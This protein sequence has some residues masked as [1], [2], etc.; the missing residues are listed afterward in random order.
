MIPIKIASLLGY[1]FGPLIRR[2]IY[3]K[4]NLESDKSSINSVINGQVSKFKNLIVNHYVKTPFGRKVLSELTN[5]DLSKKTLDNLINEEEDIKSFP[6]INRDDLINHAL[7]MLVDGSRPDKLH[8]F[9]TSGTTT[10]IQVVRYA[11]MLDVMQG[12]LS[13]LEAFKLGGI[14]PNDSI[15]ML[16]PSDSSLW[17]G[18]GLIQLVVPNLRYV[19][20]SLNLTKSQVTDLLRSKAILSYTTVPIQVFRDYDG[21]V[22]DLRLRNDINLKLIILTGGYASQ[23]NISGLRELLGKSESELKI[24]NPLMSIECTGLT[25][26]CSKGH[27]HLVTDFYHAWTRPDGELVVTSLFPFTMVYPNYLTGD[28]VDINYVEDCEFKTEPVIQFKGRLNGIHKSLRET[29]LTEALDST[30][31]QKLNLI[32]AEW[33]GTHYSGDGKEMYNLY[34]VKSKNFDSYDHFYGSDDYF[35]LIKPYLNSES[36]SISD[37]I[38]AEFFHKMIDVRKS[39]VLGLYTKGKYSNWAINLYFVSVGDELYNKHILGHKYKF[40]EVSDFND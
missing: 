30:L 14:K 26:T 15:R 36:N 33:G 19:D 9:H 40:I 16:I 21:L 24:I 2:I 1:A 35:N 18:N 28:L 11:S 8:L 17:S 20:S 34:I 38:K 6:L 13:S 22:N 39:Y 10:G 7:E 37:F 31:A 27:N 12:L 32:R 5:G 29:E 25:K 23:A 3:S 4:C